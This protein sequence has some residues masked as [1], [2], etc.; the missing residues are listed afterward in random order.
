VDFRNPISSV[1]PGTTGRILEVLTRNNAELNLTTIAGIAG[2]SPAQAS[3]VLPRL[4]E[5][6]LV[7]R[8]D[9]PPA[10]LFSMNRDHVSTGALEM[11]GRSPAS[12]VQK[13]RD[14]A[15]TIRPAPISV[16]LF[17]SA[18]RGAATSTSDIDV[19]LERSASVPEDDLDWI[20]TSTDWVLDVR[21]ATGNRVNVIE[22]TDAELPGLLRRGSSFWRSIADD[23]VHITGRPI[24]EVL[25]TRDKKSAVPSG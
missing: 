19:L 14:L 24:A 11:L 25:R 12:V 22:V 18:A 8:F 16:T 21:A 10:S 15:R 6:G 4:V 3:R 2:V 9:V 13:L 5:L 23:G 20:D 17:G 1:I 7:T